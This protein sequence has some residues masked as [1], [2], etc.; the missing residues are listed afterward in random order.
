MTEFRPSAE[1]DYSKTITLTPEL[2]YG[3]SESFLKSG[4]DNPQPT[5]QFHPTL[6]DLCCLVEKYVAIAAPRGHAKSTAVTHAFSLAAVCFRVKSHV[7]IVSDTESQ[8]K[9][10][11]NDIRREFIENE[12]LID[13]FGV[14]S[15][16]KD[17]ETELIVRFDDGHFVRFI[18]KGS[19]Q[20][21]RGT[22]W[23]GKRPDLIICDD[24][25]NDEIVMNEDRRAKFK[26]W[27]LKALIPG[28]N[29][30]CWV[31]VVGTI[32]HMDS[33][34]A[35]ITPQEEDQNVKVE[36]LRITSTKPNRVWH[37]VTFRAH[38]SVEDFQYILWREKWPEKRLRAERQ[39]Y[40][41]EGFVEGYAQE[42]LNKPIDETKAFYRKEY[43]QPLAPEWKSEYHSYY[44]ACDLAI[45]EK[46]ARAYS[47]MVVGGLNFQGQLR[48]LEV[49]RFREDTYGIITELL[50]LVQKYEPMLV[51]IEQE[52]IAKAIGPVLYQEAYKQGL[53]LNTLDLPPIADKLSRG[54]AL[55][56]LMRAGRVEFDYDAEWYH[57]LRQEMIYFP[58][59]KY[60]DQADAMA[61]LGIMIRDMV[62]APTVEEA[63]R[64]RYDD[65]YENTLE[66]FD[67]WENDNDY[68][69]EFGDDGRS[70]WTGY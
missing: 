31:R 46:K 6:W 22:K 5:P 34:L 60:A 16:V 64:D 9:N 53:D 44:I 70:D 1:P 43:F 37:S 68:A 49:R 41:D 18:A 26:K 30:D 63:E 15:I 42:Y 54:R 51:G 52:N 19:E 8:S 59:G 11:L 55:Q 7:M 47:V 36:P 35:G 38:P 14:D 58:R 69:E 57:D 21:L 17:S 48:V 40:I 66:G 2:V 27:F 33:L 24:L 10:F 29:D 61:W 65:E 3:F 23:R 32:L 20:K 28:G 4:Y 50:G 62:E 13:V 39:I 67:P 56:F 12:D 45:S 25:E